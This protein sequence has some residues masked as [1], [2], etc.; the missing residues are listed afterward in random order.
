LYFLIFV[1]FIRIAAEVLGI[2]QLTSMLNELIAYIPLIAVALLVLFIAAAIADWAARVVRPF[3]ESRN[4]GWISTA[5][6]VGVLV[7]GVLA[8]LDTLNF[9]PSVT[10][11]I[12]NTLLQYLPLAVLVA[13]TI[14]FGVGGIKTAQQWWAKLA[15]RPD[16]GAP[17][18]PTTPG[19]PAGGYGAG[20][21]EPPESPTS[22]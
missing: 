16:D 17:S 15:P 20:G 1:V 13:G 12:E 10:A 9:A 22:F 2:E 3:A 14:A 4:M 8:A 7:I 11:K 19:T 18:A 6:R 21:Q 5:I